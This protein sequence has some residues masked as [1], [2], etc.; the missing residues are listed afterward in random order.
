[1]RYEN[2]E[3]AIT[4][5]NCASRNGNDAIG[6]TRVKFIP[7]RN[8]LH[9]AIRRGATSTPKMLSSLVGC[10]KNLAVRPWPQPKSS[11][12][13][14]RED[15]LAGYVRN[16]GLY[17]RGAL[18]ASCSLDAIGNFLR[19]VVQQAGSLQI[20]SRTRRTQYYCNL[21]G[22]RHAFRDLAQLHLLPLISIWRRRL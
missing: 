2:T 19:F 4:K 9:A 21:F 7:E 16:E 15:P 10:T 3:L 12:R 20:R 5:S 18:Q 17:S 6:L 1:L 22:N 14:F 11:I 8:P 13:G